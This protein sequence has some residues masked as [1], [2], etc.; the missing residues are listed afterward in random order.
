MNGPVFL[1]AAGDIPVYAQPMYFLLAVYM[2]SS[3]SSVQDGLVWA[4]CVTLRPHSPPSGSHRARSP[5]V[6]CSTARSAISSS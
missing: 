1:F 2:V 3:A 5:R 4:L 6:P